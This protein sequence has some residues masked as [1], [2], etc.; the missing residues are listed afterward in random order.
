[1]SQP[2][3][4]LCA[5]SRVSRISL[6]SEW[7]LQHPCLSA[8]RTSLPCGTGAPHAQ[9][10][11]SLEQGWPPWALECVQSHRPKPAAGAVLLPLPAAH[12]Q[13]GPAEP[14]MFPKCVIPSHRGWTSHHSQLC[15]AKSCAPHTWT[16]SPACPAPSHM[17]KEIVQPFGLTQRLWQLSPSPALQ[18]EGLGQRW[19]RKE[20]FPWGSWWGSGGL[21]CSQGWFPRAVAMP[22]CA[23]RVGDNG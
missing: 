14:W 5:P 4:G 9:P 3:A 7:G 23:R 12:P 22:S 13:N 6:T 18:E 19:P 21:S 1:M 20:A 2:Q 17:G 8:D 11:Q 15:E 16:S 10:W